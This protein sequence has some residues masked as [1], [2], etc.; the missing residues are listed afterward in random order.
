MLHHRDIVEEIAT[1]RQGEIDAVD[2]Y[3][4]E[5][6]KPSLRR[7]RVQFL[8]EQEP[9]FQYFVKQE[10]LRLVECPHAGKCP[11]Y[12]GHTFSFRVMSQI[13]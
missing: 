5:G 9:R 12:V 8:D 1:R 4:S 11:G 10:D 3:I 7:W 13:L 6:E 2:Q